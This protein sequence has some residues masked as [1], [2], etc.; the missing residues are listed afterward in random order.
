MIDMSKLDWGASNKKSNPYIAQATG[1]GGITDTGGFAPTG[2]NGGQTGT[3]KGQAAPAGKKWILSETGEMILVDAGWD[4][5]K[6]GPAGKLYGPNGED[7]GGG[8]GGADISGPGGEN[9]ASS[10]KIKYPGL[11]DW[12]EEGIKDQYD[13][14][15]EMWSQL[16]DMLAGGNW[17][18]MGY[19]VMGAYEPEMVDT[20]ALYDAAQKVSDRYLN[21]KGA[22]L[23]EQFGVGGVRYSTPLQTNLVRETQRQA[24]NLANM[25]AQADITAQQNYQAAKQGAYENYAGRYTTGNESA[26]NQMMQAMGMMGDLGGQQATR[27]QNLLGMGADL[28][29]AQANL[30]INL[31]NSLYS[32]SNAIYGQQQGTANQ[33]NVNPYA[34]Y[35]NQ[36]G[37]T[38]QNGIPQTYNQSGASSLLGGLGS[39]LPWLQ[40]LLEGGNKNTYTPAGYN[41]SGD[42]LTPDYSKHYEL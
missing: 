3:Y 18:K 40:K 26:Q 23:A 15:P 29:Q 28:G 16:Q 10:K 27:K 2:V 36:W 17:G 7:L 22:G 32:G 5:T 20:K 9:P 38:A 42:I 24:E 41:W 1:T 13:S 21:E 14:Q 6:D 4:V 11:W 8:G 37:G 12:A 19:D 33:G 34:Q 31:A 25:Q 39:L 30:P 35:A